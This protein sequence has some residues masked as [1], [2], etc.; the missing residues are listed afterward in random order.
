MIFLKPEYLFFMLIPLVVLFYF[1]VTNKNRL[2]S[3]FD[4]S[5]LEKLTFD[6]DSLGR[7]GRNIML[8]VALFSFIIA[9]ARPVFEKGDVQIKTKSI[10]MMVALDVSKSMQARDIYPNRLAFAKKQFGAFVDSFTEANVGVIAFSSEGFLVSPMTQDTSTLKYLV[11]NLSLDSMSLKGTNLMIPIEKAKEFLKDSNEKIVIIFTDGGDESDFSHEIEAA[12]EYGI[13]I[14]IYAIGTQMGAPIKDVDGDIKD[15]K[16]N[17]VIS[18]LNES[19]KPLA[20]E[21][22]GAYIMGGYKDNSI[23]LMVEDI[24]KKFEI[25]DLKSKNIKEYQEL[26][27]YFVGLGLLFMLFSFSSLPKRSSATFVLFLMVGLYAPTD[28]NARVFDFIDIDQAKEAYTQEKYDEAKVLFDKVKTSKKSPQSIYNY[29]NAEYK[30][31][32]YENAIQSYQSVKTVDKSLQY[33]KEF[34]I[35]NSYFQL[36]EYEKALEAYEKAQK[37]KTE[38][39]LEYNI[40]LTKKKLEEQNQQNK[41]DQDQNQEEKDKDKK[42]QQENKDD[43][44]KS[45]NDKKDQ[46]ENKE[47]DSKKKEEKK[48]PN[49]DKKGDQKNKDEKKKDQQ[50][51]EQ[52]PSNK[53]DEKQKIT[54]KEIQKWQEQLEKM[55][56]KTM[57]LRFESSEAERKAD[58]KPW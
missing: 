30:N 10:D 25:R 42:D 55:Q 35:G 8:F 53:S 39:D 49:K 9:L 44:Q 11:N 43:Q 34:N 12:K 19:I 17:I 45:Q 18:K 3:V 23:P 6:N 20:L 41:N 40:E 5:I 54:P 13:S 22:N 38:D 50:N 51:K 15:A 32:N 58:E 14:Y 52:D 1:I 16:G 36:Q 33:K 46:E 21:T 28:A 31:Q 26:F 27:Y 48:E 7:I 47:N 37:I 57:P 56:P 2:D 29:A 24:K 4:P